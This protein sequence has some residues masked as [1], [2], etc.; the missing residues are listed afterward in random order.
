MGVRC[1]TGTGRAWSGSQQ[2]TPPCVTHTSCTLCHSAG[3][4]HRGGA[5][6]EDPG[7]QPWRDCHPYL[8]GGHGAGPAHGE[9]RRLL[10]A[11]QRR[12][13]R[14]S[15]TLPLC[16]RPAGRRLQ[17]RRQ[18]A[19]TPLQCGRGIPGRW[20]HNAAAWGHNTL[21]GGGAQG[22]PPWST[23]AGSLGQG[24]PQQP[25]TRHGMTRGWARRWVR[26]TCSPWPAT[27]TLSL[28]WQWQRRRAWTPSTRGACRSTGL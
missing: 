20:G 6:P 16:P 9:G 14:A 25:Q 1:S 8:P 11:A 22:L 18:A 4:P 10:Q 2:G 3:G 19:A 26:L 12:R 15:P 24:S 5:L 28:C 23:P 7:R 17:P 21:G 27:W 13:S